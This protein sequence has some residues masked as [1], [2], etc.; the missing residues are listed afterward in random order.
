MAEDHDAVLTPVPAARWRLARA[1]TSGLWRE[2]GGEVAVYHPPSASTHLLEG[3]SAAVFSVLANTAGES[4]SESAILA[5]LDPGDSS[6]ASAEEMR[7]LRDIL[8]SLQ[9]SGLAECR[10][11]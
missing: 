10:A 7:R 8:D 4:L 1:V 11:S 9:H 5:A 2:V 6:A 3:A